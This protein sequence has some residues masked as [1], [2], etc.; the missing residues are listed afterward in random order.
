MFYKKDNSKTQMGN[1][2][3]FLS[4]DEED[5]GLVVESKG[6]KMSVSEGQ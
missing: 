3:L 6:K 4:G 2:A 1:D 5:D